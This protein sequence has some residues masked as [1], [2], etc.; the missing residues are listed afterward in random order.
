MITFSMFS[1]MRLL[2]VNS[3]T[4]NKIIRDE[5]KTWRKLQN[6][7]KTLENKNVAEIHLVNILKYVF[8]KCFGTLPRQYCANIASCDDLAQMSLPCHEVIFLVVK[9]VATKHFVRCKL[10]EPF[11]V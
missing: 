9:I 6:S 10:V 11:P 2:F 1:I 7:C 4:T 5:N 3:T 8:E